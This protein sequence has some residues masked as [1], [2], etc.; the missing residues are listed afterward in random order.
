MYVPAHFDAGPEAIERL[1]S[2]PGASN[3][4]TMTSKG[5]IAT[6]VPFVF[7]SS[8]GEHGALLGHLARNNPHWSEEAVG[9]SLVL[10]Q[11]PDAYITPS[12]YAAKAEHGRVVPTWNYSTAH[13]YGDLIIHD[14]PAW[15]GNLVRR[16]TDLHEASAE[17]PWSVD[18]APEKYVAGQLRAIVGI[19]LRIT[20]VE[21]K[22]KQ[23][24][25]RSAADMEGVIAGLEG[26][27]DQASADAVRD[28]RR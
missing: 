5:M 3:L 26:V 15:L 14:D 10:V 18:D 9:E 28:A 8:L 4:V 25:N 1:L 7:D 19:E 11:G 21:A 27:G 12:W 6:M 13:V 16:L 22:L 17:H 2:H 20:R 24:Q 23:S